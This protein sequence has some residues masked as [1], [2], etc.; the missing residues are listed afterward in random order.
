MRRYYRQSLELRSRL[1]L[2]RE[3]GAI[4]RGED[5]R[6]RWKSL[7]ASRGF[8]PI[9]SSLKT[10]A[11]VR[12]RC[13]YCC[14]SRSCDVDH[15]VP[16]TLDASKTMSWSNLLWVC[17]DCNRR[18]SARYDPYLLNPFEEDPW[19]HFVFIEQSGE[20]APRWLVDN[21]EDPYARVTLSILS[22]LQHEAVTEGRRRSYLR[23]RHA[24]EAWLGSPGDRLLR[25]ALVASFRED[26]YGVGAWLVC[27]EGRLD[28]PWPEVER[29]DPRLARRL[30]SLAS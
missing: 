28:A 8:V 27:H 19:R 29:V 3:A 20:V 25:E 7:R 13:M 16:V 24:A 15:F 26:E 4:A 11:G 22:A 1:L 30:R 21:Q 18:K 23:M 10:A 6:E 9:L 14:D 2:Q 12:Q 5:A 17:T